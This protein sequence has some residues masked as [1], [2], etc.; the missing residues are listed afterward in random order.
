LC[1]L[2]DR[3]IKILLLVEYLFTLAKLAEDRNIPPQ[4]CL[5][6]IP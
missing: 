2:P 3:F 4:L 6:A 5:P 1:L